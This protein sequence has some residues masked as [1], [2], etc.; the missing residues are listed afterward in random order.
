MYLLCTVSTWSNS[1]PFSI[2][3]WVFFQVLSKWELQRFLWICKE[4]YLPPSLPDGTFLQSNARYCTKVAKPGWVQIA[5][6][7]H[8]W[9]SKD[10]AHEG[11][12]CRR[13]LQVIWAWDRHWQIHQGS[14]TLGKAGSIYSPRERCLPAPML[15]NQQQACCFLLSASY[16]DRSWPMTRDSPF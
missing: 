10:A 4:G 16:R 5:P 11:D 8:G 2:M 3:P 9:H 6:I 14:F 13:A 7:S 1:R 15:T 12:R